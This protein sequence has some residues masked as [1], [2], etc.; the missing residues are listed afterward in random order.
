MGSE[1]E[2]NIRSLAELV[3]SVFKLKKYVVISKKPDIKADI[4]RYVPSIKRAKEKL[5]LKQ[6]INLQNAI[7]KTIKYIEFQEGSNRYE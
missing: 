3:S 7:K 4:E 1:E 5:N 6:M 2:I